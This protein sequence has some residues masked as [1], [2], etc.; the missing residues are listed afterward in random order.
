[1]WCDGKEETEEVSWDSP[2]VWDSK[3]NKLRAEP[4]V[5]VSGSLAAFT[6]NGCATWVRAEA[7][8]QELKKKTGRGNGF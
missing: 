5:V 3:Q 8:F 4:W 7:C 6:E 1:M 2:L